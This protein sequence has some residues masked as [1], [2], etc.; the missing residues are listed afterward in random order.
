MKNTLFLLLVLIWILVLFLLRYVGE[1]INDTHMIMLFIA[2]FIV[3][4]VLRKIF[5]ISFK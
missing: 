1:F 2:S 3:I 5:F 4:L